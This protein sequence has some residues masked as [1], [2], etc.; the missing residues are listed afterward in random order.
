MNTKSIPGSLLRILAIT[1]SLAAPFALSQDD[2]QENEPED[3]QEIQPEKAQEIVQDDSLDY[4]RELPSAY[5]SSSHEI[6][7]YNRAIKEAESR[8]GAYGGSLSES[9]LGLAQ[10]LQSQGRH[11]EAIKMFKRGVHLTRINE[12]LYCSQQIPM[13]QGEIASHKAMKSYTQADERQ[14]YLYRVQIKSI[15]SSEALVTAFMD[16]AKWQYDAYQLRLE[17]QDYERLINMWELYR[18]AFNDVIDREGTK[19]PNLLPP[20]YGMLQAQYLISGYQIQ[21][22]TPVFTDDGNID[23][24]LLRFRAYIAK[25]YQQG[26]IIIAAIA[27][28]EKENDAPDSAAIA[29]TLV[30]LGDWRL[31]NG[32]GD[33]A[34]EAYRNAAT[35]LARED[36]AQEKVQQLFGTPVALPAIAGINPLPPAV[37]PTEATVTLA[38][39]VSAYGK[40]RD[41]ERLDDNENDDSQASR[42][43]RQLRK[44]I[45]R[46]RIEAGQPVETEKLVKA[47]NIQ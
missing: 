1:F 41:I 33:A 6:L 37:A 19:S 8:E 22:S 35:E 9:M 36:D 34:W 17:Q 26:N 7:A 5:V 23:E 21:P 14:N 15:G 3:Q 40:V 28:L 27:D 24:G 10:T 38:F 42:L 12:G 13:L 4:A 43:M 39:G 30:M 45:F 46:P 11:D 47:F 18:V 20:L 31:W 25:S 29:Q 2:V 16:Q 44:T 32:K